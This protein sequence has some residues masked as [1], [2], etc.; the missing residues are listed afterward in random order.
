MTVKIGL[1]CR[2]CGLRHAGLGRYVKNLALRLPFCLPSD[3]NLVYFFADKTQW[4]EVLA[5][6]RELDLAKDVKAG[7]IFK[8][9]KIVIAPVRHYSWREQI[10]MAKIF[11]SENLDLLH[12]PHF[13]L[14]YF[15]RVAKIVVT[16]H[17]LT[18]H[19]QK[20][21]QATTLPAWQYHLKYLAYKI[22]FSRVVK[23]AR[24]I[25]VPSKTAGADLAH[26]YP[27]SKQKIEVIYNGVND[28]VL[29][30]AKAPNVKLPDKYL[31]YVGSLYPHKNVSLILLAMRERV[32]LNLVIVGANDS[33][34]ERM[35]K[36]ID[37]LGL[38]K[39]VIMLSK[40]S[41][42]TLKYLYQ[43]AQALVQPSLAEGFG[44]TGVEAMAVGAMVMASKIRIFEEIYGEVAEYFQPHLVSSFLLALE[45]I[46]KRDLRSLNNQLK[47][48][49][50][51]FSWQ[52]M[53]E[54]VGKIYQRVLDE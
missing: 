9:I 25:I 50:G 29:V 21:I 6:L 17:D 27:K 33:F 37:D 47:A 35:K 34:W 13:N 22:L 2:L 44:L 23:K 10:Q 12:V 14:P 53:T 28:F 15:I 36:E 3:Y 30:T 19:R 1:D 52:K 5:D 38:E 40:V 46:E 26:Y 4:S 39:R 51:R 42:E 24:R 8:R 7:E 45:K 11:E 18:W 41:D 20:G 32:D 54:Q 49:A 16:I 43:K 48:R 31:L